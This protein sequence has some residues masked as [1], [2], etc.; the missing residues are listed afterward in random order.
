MFLRNGNKFENILSTQGQKMII[1]NAYEPESIFTILAISGIDD[2][3]YQ[4][5]LEK[6]NSLTTRRRNNARVPYLNAGVQ[7]WEASF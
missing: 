3:A 1:R 7:L 4:R 2:Q 6:S 5:Y